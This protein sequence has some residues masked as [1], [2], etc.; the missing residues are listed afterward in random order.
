MTIDALR[1][2]LAANVQG[3]RVAPLGADDRRGGVEASSGR[4]RSRHRR[5]PCGRALRSIR[6]ARGSFVVRFRVGD[7]SGGEKPAS[8]VGGRHRR[9]SHAR[10]ARASGRRDRHHPAVLAW[11]GVRSRR[12]RLRSADPERRADPAVRTAADLRP[13]RSRDRELRRH[14]RIGGADAVRRKSRHAP[15][16][17]SCRR[18]RRRSSAF[19]ELQA[20][21]LG[22]SLDVPIRR[23]RRPRIAARKPLCRRAPRRGAGRGRGGHQQRGARSA[24]GSPRRPDHLRTALRCV[25]VRQSHRADHAERQRSSVGGWPTRSGKAVEARLA[26]Q[27]STCA[28][29]VWRT[30]ST[31]ICS[32]AAATGFTTTIGCSS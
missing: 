10:R 15:I 9:R 7:L 22:V 13:T 16:R 11:P 28:R 20:T 32:A 4:R 17:P 8:W 5:R 30:A 25:P 12:R 19:I 31:S 27:E 24:G 2:T 21:T 29:V 23:R 26:F 18:W 6:S 14:D 3:L 1:S